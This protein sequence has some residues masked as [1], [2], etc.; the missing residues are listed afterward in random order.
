M[1]A[2]G[3][4]TYTQICSS[5]ARTNTYHGHGSFAITCIHTHTH[6]HVNTY[7]RAHTHARKHVW[8]SFTLYVQH[9]TQDPRF[10]P[11]L[12]HVLPSLGAV[13]IKTQAQQF[14]SLMQTAAAVQV[15]KRKKEKEEEVA[16]VLSYREFDL[17]G[18]HLALYIH[19]KPIPVC[20][21]MSFLF[22]TGLLTCAHTDS[23]VG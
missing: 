12:A 15:G 6:K 7:T 5:R 9:H 21:A 10:L 14:T 16:A 2:I 8:Q 4:H 18:P 20:F 11:E 13:A 17:P 22:L 19:M 3:T 1:I 23:C